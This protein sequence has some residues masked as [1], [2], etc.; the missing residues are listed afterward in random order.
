M[1]EA[2]KA[3]RQTAHRGERLDLSGANLTGAN[4]TGANLH[5][6]KLVGADLTRADLSEADLTFAW[7]MRA[8]FTHAR[9]HGAKLQPI[10]TSTGMDNTRDQA[11]IFVGAELSDASITAHFSYDD[12]RGVNFSYAHMT[13]T[14]ANQSMGMLRPEFTSTNLAVC[15]SGL[16]DQTVG[17]GRD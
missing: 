9:L 7:I 12:M 15:R 13:V 11:A 17:I 8:N 14:M 2:L 5:G 16:S 1:E 6:V 4:L 10:I 3:H